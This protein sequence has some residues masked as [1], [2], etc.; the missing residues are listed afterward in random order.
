METGPHGMAAPRWRRFFN[1]PSEAK[2]IASNSSWLFGDKILRLAIGAPISFWMARHLGPASF[3]ELNYALAFT[4]IFGAIAAAG[5][6]GIV[7]RE[8]VRRP[9][10]AS[11]TLSTA[12]ALKAATGVIAFAACVTTAYLVDGAGSRELI[13]VSIIGAGLLFQMFDVLDYWFQSQVKSSISV[14]ARMIAFASC[15]CARIVLILN[16]GSLVDF[17]V[18]AFVEIALGAACLSIGYRRSPHS[19]SGTAPRAGVALNLLKDG[20]PLLLSGVAVMLYMR[21]DM[22]MLEKMT[23]SH[24]VGIYAAAT[25]VSEIW[26]VLPMAIASSVLPSLLRRRATD[27]ASYLHSLRRF[28]FLLAW[29]ALTIAI[30]L[31]LCADWVVLLLYGTDFRAAGPVLAIHLW[32]SYAVFLGVG[33]S[34]YLLAENLQ[35]YS[36]YRTLFGLATN[37]ILN[38]ALIPP[39]GVL[40]AAIATVVSYFVSVFSLVFFPS[41]RAHAMLMLVA[42]FHNPR[43]LLQNTR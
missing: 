42:P 35:V 28:Y 3:G 27:P 18:V 20:W 32:A 23:G 39:F 1:L 7:I 41:T 17:A 16:Q 11:V 22:V 38:L 15:S 43:S 29:L 34:Q 24:A 12:L 9:A 40:G 25:K 4:A 14:R 2:A 37:V 6:D 13:L 10:F 5:L 8:L 26:Y 21:I 31:S 36:L 30:P 33:S 19:P